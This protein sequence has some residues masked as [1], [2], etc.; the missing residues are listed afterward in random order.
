MLDAEVGSDAEHA[1]KNTTVDTTANDF[2]NFILLPSFKFVAQA[3]VKNFIQQCK[4][5]FQ[6]FLFID[7]LT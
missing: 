7:L 3:R 6:L 4:V 2:K 5:F 1:A